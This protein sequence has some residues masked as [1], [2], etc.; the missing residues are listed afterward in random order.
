M[1]DELT[2]SAADLKKYT[3]KM[4]AVIKGKIA[5]EGRTMGEALEK[6]QKKYPATPA[7]EITVLSV[8][9]HLPTGPHRSRA[10]APKTTARLPQDKKL[11]TV[12]YE[13]E[14]GTRYAIEGKSLQHYQESIYQLRRGSL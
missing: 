12:I 10:A 3:G 5:A 9:E 11:V 7:R 2:I 6:A 4:I 8:P 1:S 14:D 13:Y